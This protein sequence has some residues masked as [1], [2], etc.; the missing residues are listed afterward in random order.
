[1]I[2]NTIK[3]NLFWVL[4]LVG[5]I[6]LPGCGEGGTTLMEY[7]RFRHAQ[8]T[9]PETMLKIEDGKIDSVHL[10]RLTRPVLVR[11]YGTED[12]TDCAF[13][14]MRDNLKNLSLSKK[15]GSFDFIVIMAPPEVARESVIDRA[16]KMSLPLSV[17][18]DDTYCLERQK[19]FP[20][21]SLLHIFLLDVNGRPVFI[22]SPLRDKRNL[23]K[24]TNKIESLQV[25]N[26]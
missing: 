10:G 20:S 13:S 3:A 18:I 25:N 23:I 4:L 7:V 6:L 2:W 9:L 14:H 15:V 26:P 22:G 12:C 1:M 19:A 24:F 21:S 5:S 16:V 11:Y 17:L 8:I